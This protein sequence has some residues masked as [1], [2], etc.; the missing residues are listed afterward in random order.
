MGEAHHLA[1][2]WNFGGPGLGLFG[3]RFLRKTA[4]AF[5]RHPVVSSGRRA[6]ARGVTAVWAFFR[7]G[8]HIRKDKATSNICSNQAFIA[9]LVGAALLERGDAGLGDILQQMRSKVEEAVDAL[10]RFDGVELAFPE[11]VS[12][13]E[14]TLQ[15]SKPVAE[16]LTRAHAAG[17]LAG[18]DVSDRIAG[19]R[20]LL[21]LSFGNRAQSLGELLDVFSAVFGPAGTSARAC[22]RP[23]MRPP[24]G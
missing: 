21:K 22:S 8:Q 15:L 23:P 9:T 14:L 1:L 19:E 13:H 24:Y 4:T 11:S 3:V 16:V 2:A 7:L 12:F 5:A 17:V 20:H 6:I 18:A 10:T